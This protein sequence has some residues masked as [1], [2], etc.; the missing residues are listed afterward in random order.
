MVKYTPI[1]TQILNL[2]TGG[3]HL[4]SVQR[5]VKPQTLADYIRSELVK[6]LISVSI[7]Q[8]HVA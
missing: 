3:A 6:K 8:C 7:I 1:I 4:I 5:D 2:L